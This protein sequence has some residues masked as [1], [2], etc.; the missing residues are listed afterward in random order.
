VSNT[1]GCVSLTLPFGMSTGGTASSTPGLHFDP[2]RGLLSN[3]STVLAPFM[4]IFKIIG[5]AK[6]ITDCVKA[7][8]DCITQLSPKPLVD[9]LAKVVADIDQLLEVLPPLSVPVM[10]RDLIGALI[11][12]LEGLQSQIEGLMALGRISANLEVTADSLLDS[13]PDAA[14]ALTAI[15]QA[16]IGDSTSMVATLDSQQCAFNTLIGAIINLCALLGLPVP[17]LLPCFGGASFSTAVDLLAGL[18]V[19]DDAIGDVIALLSDLAEILGG[20]TAPVQPC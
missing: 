20:A 3:F 17:P 9:K 4:P 5:F 2:M 7:I 12:A 19:V 6:D 18:Q 15:V 8:P 14:G 16:S 10:L 1:G 11:T 13:D